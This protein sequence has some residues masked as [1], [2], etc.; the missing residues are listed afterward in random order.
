MVW[1][2]KSG[3]EIDPGIHHPVA[4][5]EV[6]MKSEKRGETRAKLLERHVLNG[7]G[8]KVRK[9]SVETPEKVH[10]IVKN[11]QILGLSTWEVAML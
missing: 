5:N 4:K 8:Q 3:L 10:V 6:R 1:K 2:L 7:G 11:E 9:K